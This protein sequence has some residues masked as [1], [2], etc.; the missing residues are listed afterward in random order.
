M[1]N[2]DLYPTPDDVIQQMLFLTDITDGKVLDPSAGFGNILDYA[3]KHT[4][5]LFCYE[6]EDRLQPILKDKKYILLGE[7][8]LKSKKEE[9]S[10]ITHIIMNPPFSKDVEHILHAFEIAPD[11]CEV[12]AL[13]NSESLENNYTYSRKRLLNLISDYGT[14]QILGSVF[15]DAERSTDVSVGLVKLYKPLAS[16][17]ID[18]DIFFMEEDEEVSAG[19]GLMQYNEVRALVN[20]YVG[21]LKQFDVMQ[22]SLS[23]IND[24][25]KIIGMSSLSYE[26]SQ[27]RGFTDKQTFAKNLQKSSWRYIFNKMN[28]DKYLTSKM[29]D[30]VNKF[31]EDQQ[32]V[33]FT[34]RNIFIMLDMIFQTRHENLQNALVDAVDNLT[35]YTHENR[36]ELP[37]WKTNLGHMLNKKIIINNIVSMNYRKWSVNY[38]SSRSNLED[39]I[40]VLCNI[41]STDFNKID[42]VREWIKDGYETSTW[43]YNEFFEFKFYKKGTM[44]LK[45]KDLNHWKMLNEYYGKVKGFTLPSNFN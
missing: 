34:M 40:K 19:S 10:H 30:K 13:C 9:V 6:I 36:Y 23:Y 44:H 45:F 26:M 29:I 42:S 11:G 4:N 15:I 18:Y 22:E 20:R 2:K 31:V 38:N 43:Y 5:N 24:N 25:G 16:N 14:S 12:I 28:M 8:F 3:K 39:L 33:P 32:K 27:N 17:D 21:I 37:G 35:R 41:T 1:I 7:D